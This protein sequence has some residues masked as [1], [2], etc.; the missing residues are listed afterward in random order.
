MRRG[1]RAVRTVLVL[2]T[3]TALGA[4]VT[5]AAGGGGT[6]LTKKRALKLF[7]K[8]A[9][10]DARFVE[11]RGKILISAGPYDWV[12]E[13]NQ[14][15]YMDYGAHAALLLNPAGSGNYWALLSAS[16]PAVVYG[17]PMAVESV[18]ICYD[19]TSSFSHIS[20]VFVRVVRATAGTGTTIAEIADE[21][22]L[23]DQACRLYSYPGPVTLTEDD[24]IAVGVRSSFSGASNV[25]FSRAT[26]TL[27]P[28][29]G[30]GT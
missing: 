15:A 11:D 13:G 3:A 14:N 24:Y 20:A 30:P 23:D 26:V 9:K 10:A 28:T 7:Y 19:A 12:T 29:D 25:Q 6:P 17:Q 18:E 1:S 8:R 27:A 5:G 16:L 2:V 22:D 4:S 21:T